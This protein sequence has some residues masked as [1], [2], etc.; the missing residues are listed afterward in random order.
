[1]ATKPTGLTGPLRVARTE[2]GVVAEL[3]AVGWPKDQ[4][5]IERKILTAFIR[6]FERFGAKVYEMEAGGTEDLDFLLT[7][8][9]GKSYLELMEIV[10]PRKGE[11]P[12]Q[13]GNHS[14]EALEYAEQVYS[15]IQRKADKYGFRHALPIDLLL[16]F[17][18]ALYSPSE[19]GELALRRFLLDRKHPFHYV[20]LIK[21]IDD[22][23][24][25]LRVL[26]NHDYP[27]PAPEIAE[28]RDKRW[29]TFDLMS[30]SVMHRAPISLNELAWTPSTGMRGWW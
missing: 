12:Y 29:V 25:E 4:A 28:L 11:L 16:Y 19:W 13:A 23:T 24:A 15:G 27:S 3:L 7:L 9:G 8:P 1:M 20:F 22:E 2:S 30:G 5:Q 17:T 6:E 10:A 18:H 14:Y 26:F 21:S